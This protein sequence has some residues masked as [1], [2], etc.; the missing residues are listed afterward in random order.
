MSEAEAMRRYAEKITHG[1]IPATDMVLEEA[2]TSTRT[3]AVNSL[4]LA[5]ERA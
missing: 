3:N 2:S 1:G 4:Q 5:A